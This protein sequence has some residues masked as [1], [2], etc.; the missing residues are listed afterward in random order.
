MNP[1]DERLAELEQLATTTSG[2]NEIL[3]LYEQAA[4]IQGTTLPPVDITI[5]QMIQ[6]ILD[7]DFPPDDLSR[8]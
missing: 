5:S 3:R 7:Y 8:L 2:Q 1:R 6:A 4:G